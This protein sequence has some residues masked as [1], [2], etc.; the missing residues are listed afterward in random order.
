MS[1]FN[2]CKNTFYYKRTQLVK[3][4]NTPKTPFN[5][6]SITFFQFTGKEK[7]GL[8]RPNK[9]KNCTARS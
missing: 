7:R 4:K 2:A 1:Y 8:K 6:M 3:K 9:R 5:K